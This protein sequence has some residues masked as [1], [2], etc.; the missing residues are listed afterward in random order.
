MK[1]KRQPVFEEITCT[2]CGTVF[3]PEAYDDIMCT[4]IDADGVNVLE[5]ECPTCGT[6]HRCKTIGYEF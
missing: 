2:K 5:I 1:I 3:V 6:Y 4:S